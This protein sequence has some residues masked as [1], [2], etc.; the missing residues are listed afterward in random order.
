MA[1]GFFDIT[2]VELSYLGDELT[3]AVI[4]DV[5][6]AEALNL[7]IPITDVDAPFNINVSDGGIDALVK[8]TPKGLGNGIIFAPRTSY[9]IKAGKFGLT[10]TTKNKI[11]ELLIQPKA[12]G[13]R[14]AKKGVAPSGSAHTVEDLS[15]RVRECLDNGG[16]FVVVLFGDSSTID[17]TEDDATENA[18]RAFLGEIDAKYATAQIKPDSGSRKESLR[19]TLAEQCDYLG[20]TE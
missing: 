14:K 10:P 11:E 13:A 4:R 20:R 17:S 1:T 9:Q 5:L 6:C 12:I 7:G 8:G 2:P 3:V 15:P 18:I 19:I 16:T